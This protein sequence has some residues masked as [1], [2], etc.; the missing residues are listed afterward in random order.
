MFKSKKAV[1]PL[2]A[3]VLL[4]AFAVA[5]GAVVM[6]YSGSLGE[7][8]SVSIQITETS[9]VPDICFN[10]D[11]S[12]LEFILENGAKEE[13]QGVK[14]TIQGTIDI[15][16]DDINEIVGVSETKKITVAYPET[17][18]GSISK[19]KIIPY[20]AESDDTLTICPTDK[21]IIVEGIIDC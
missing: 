14:V 10:Q 1:S 12:H 16:N 21:S 15:L 13:L 6:T 4:I 3:T 7:C 5:L 20:I 9:S 11:T 18:H 17:S 8:G 2:I 19:I